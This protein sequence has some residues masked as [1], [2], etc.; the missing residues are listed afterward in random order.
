M[1]KD[2][3]DPTRLLDGWNAAAPSPQPELDLSGLFQNLHGEATPR[4]EVRL[5]AER[6]AR[7]KKRGFEMHD[8]E[9]IEAPEICLPPI[10]PPLPVDTAGLGEALRAA[11]QLA[12]EMAQAQADAPGGALTLDLPPNTAPPAEPRLLTHWQPGAWMAVRRRAL[13]ASTAVLNTPDGPLV[14]TLAPQWLM[15]VWPP[16]GLDQPW[17]SRWPERAALVGA[18]DGET[19]A[20]RLLAA[21]VPAQ[22]SMWLAER[23]VDWGLLADLVLHHDAALQPFQIQALRSLAEAERLAQFER[24]NSAYEAATAEQPLRRKRP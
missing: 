10:A 15:A 2:N 22:A 19:A 16:Q 7:L 14:E 8:V 12:Q 3:T 5:D 1:D 11:S 24:L 13:G 6:V 9:D 17:L 18:D 23:E 4:R 20:R 21:C